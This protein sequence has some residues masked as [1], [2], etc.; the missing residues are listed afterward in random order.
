[1]ETNAVELG[2]FGFSRVLIK[3]QSVEWVV[4]GCCFE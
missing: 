4:L 3:E 2:G 1:M